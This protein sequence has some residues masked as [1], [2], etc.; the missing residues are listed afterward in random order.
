MTSSQHISPNPFDNLAKL[1]AGLAR[2][3][4]F[5]DR[6]DISDALYQKASAE[7]DAL[8]DLVCRAEDDVMAAPISSDADVTA[9]LRVITERL[10]LGS[11]ATESLKR[12]QHQVEHLW[13]ATAIGG[14]YDDQF[15]KLTVASLDSIAGA[16]VVTVTTVLCS[17]IL[18]R[19]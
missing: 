6:E 14:S 16:K 19:K 3:G 10:R 7:Y 5:L 11:D 8:F 13:S 1:R 2:L 9:K 18:C 15:I 17:D 4:A 12:L